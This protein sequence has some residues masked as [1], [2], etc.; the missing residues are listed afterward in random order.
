MT[1]GAR[2]NPNTGVIWIVSACRFAEAVSIGMLIPIIP[3]LIQDVET[4]WLERLLGHSL[5]AEEL[6]AIVFSL[7]GFAMAAIQ[8]LAGRLSD[9]LD[10]RKPFIV[11]GMLGGVVCT[12]AFLVVSNFAELATTRVL[13][14]IFFGFTF[15]PLMAIIAYHAPEGRGGRV[16]GLYSTFRLVGFGMGPLL[17][18]WVT[19]VWGRDALF[20]LSASLLFLSI[21]MVSIWVPD[22]RDRSR[23]N[24]NS[25]RK[26][27]LPRVDPRFYIHGAVIFFMMVGISSVMSFF[28]YYERTYGASERQLGMI[29]G[30]FVLTRCVFQFPSGW[31][32]DRY[33]KK[34]VLL[35]S[36]GIYIPLTAAMGFVTS[37]DQLLFLRLGLGAVAAGITASV[38]GMSAERSSPGARARIMGI[39]TM[40]F[41]MGVAVGPLGGF[42]GRWSYSTP[43]VVA[44]CGGFVVLILVWAVLQS[45]RQFAAHK[46]DT[47]SPEPPPEVPTPVAVTTNPK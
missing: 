20:Q 9:S 34:T 26:E 28:P 37:L 10:R 45:D 43:F 15:P 42:L 13:Q 4:P 8:L 38:A 40:S 16:L 46:R 5:V 44:A 3:G 14:G 11:G 7:T 23:A 27:P 39:N 2:D 32:G 47:T 12:L 41:S 22:F 35:I 6:T 36:L 25:A 24:K 33:D 31:I 1:T 30:V 29:Y 21:V 17:G 19:E 18:G